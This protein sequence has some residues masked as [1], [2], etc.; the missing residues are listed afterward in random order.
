MFKYAPPPAVTQLKNGA[1]KIF[2]RKH[3]FFYS[4]AYVL[5]L[6]VFRP[7]ACFYSHA[8][9]VIMD[10]LMTCTLFNAEEAVAK[11]R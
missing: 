1:A 7:V 10:A 5:K 11:Y 9:S 4:N 2:T 3:K 8:R 6:L